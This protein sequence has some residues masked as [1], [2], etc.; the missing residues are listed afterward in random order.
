MPLTGSELI[1]RIPSMVQVSTRAKHRALAESLANSARQTMAELGHQEKAAELFDLFRKCRRELKSQNSRGAEDMG[2]TMGELL[3]KESGNGFGDLSPE[4]LELLWLGQQDHFESLTTEFNS[5]RSKATH[6]L[7]VLRPLNERY[8]REW[9]SVIEGFDET[10]RAKEADKIRDFE[11]HDKTDLGVWSSLVYDLFS[12]TAVFDQS[13]KSAYKKTAD[14]Q[15]TDGRPLVPTGMISEP[16]ERIYRQQWR[17]WIR[18]NEEKIMQY[19]KPL[20]SGQLSTK[21]DF[22][23]PQQNLTNFSENEKP[24]HRQMNDRQIEISLALESDPSLVANRAWNSQSLTYK[25]VDS[26]LNMMSNA[27]DAEDSNLRVNVRFKGQAGEGDL[28]MR[29]KNFEETPKKLHNLL[30]AIRKESHDG[31]PNKDI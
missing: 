2:L 17:L 9:A 31:Q 5:A 6:V 22:V 4:Q 28:T 11:V 24:E 21:F 30:D 25:D 13:K 10:Y 16:S 23:H 7:A 18:E 29:T 14:I 12:S 27:W 19:A 15:L 20:D 26:W 1:S 8:F 3:W